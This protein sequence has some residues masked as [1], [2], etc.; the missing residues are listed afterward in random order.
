MIL[1]L[2]VET[3]SVNRHPFV[4]HCAKF[5]DKKL[6]LVSADRPYHSKKLIEI[7]KGVPMIFIGGEFQSTD[8]KFVSAYLRLCSLPTYLCIYR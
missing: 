6:S 5:T 8:R 2:E 3:S 7:C 1:F 4:L